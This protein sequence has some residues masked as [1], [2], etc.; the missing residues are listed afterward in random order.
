M[1]EIWPFCKYSKF[2]DLLLSHHFMAAEGR[3][4]THY[5]MAAEG[6][7][8]THHLMA[9]EGRQRRQLQTDPVCHTKLLLGIAG[10][11]PSP[12]P[13]THNTHHKTSYCS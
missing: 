8:H 13:S 1:F 7:Q 5:L 9:A 4:H 3:Q 12:L 2:P 11:A 10:R 6:R